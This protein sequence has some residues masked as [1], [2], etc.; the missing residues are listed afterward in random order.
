MRMVAQPGFFDL[1]ERLARL[2][3]KGDELE[4][5]SAV[6]D[7]ELF[8]SELERAVPRADR[9]KGGRPPF[10][11][12]LMFKVL[13]L[14]TRN[15]LSDERTEF[16]LRDRLSWMRFLG[17]GLGDPTPDANTIWTFREALTR[18]GAI[19]PL[20]TLFDQALRTAGYLA[21][22]GQL[23]D[24]TIVAAPRQHNSKAEKQ[25]LKEGRIP[26]GWKEKPAKLRQK[27]RDARWTVKY[28][29][30][31]PDAD[32]EL[33]PVDIAIPA[34]GYQNHIGADRRHRLIRRW[35]VTDA[36]AHA[37][38]RLGELLDP[39]N[40]AAGVWADTAYRSK[41][42]EALL[43]DRMLASHIH[44]KK[45]RGRPMPINVARANGKRSA[46]RAPIEHIFACQKDQMGLFV[47]TIGM[48]RARTKIGLANLVYN[49]KRLTWL[50]RAAVPA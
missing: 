43:Q 14:Q 23:V 1:E 41:K 15:N 5:L 46:I 49:M 9:A 37:G 18:A 36:A 3:A 28:T 45:P 31:K 4:R 25:A 21:M 50:A 10:D 33:P 22:S 40:T 38:A 48:A 44:R 39:R 30:A 16:Y 13:M 32:G 2:S 12:V 20:F 6:V 34:F 26:D 42:N 29:R 47:R 19:E 8:R 11:H 17:L 27:D 35:T 7:F 24:A